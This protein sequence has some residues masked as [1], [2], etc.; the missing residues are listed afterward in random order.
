[1]D[2]IIYTKPEVLDHKKGGD[3]HQTY[4]WNFGEREPKQFDEG[5]RIFFA[6]KGFIVGS[7]LCKEYNEGDE[8]LIVWD[9]DSW[10]PLKTPIPCKPF[11]GF[12]YVKGELI[13]QIKDS[14]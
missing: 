7:F 3:G 6:V 11:Q 10:E 9:K 5:D 2:I 8:E 4:Y 12:K 13:E 14:Y 1:M